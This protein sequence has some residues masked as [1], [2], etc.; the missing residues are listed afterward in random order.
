M[1]RHLLPQLAADAPLLA[2][3]LRGELGR[4]QPLDC[5]FPSTTPTSLV[6][7]GTGAQPG[8]HGVLGF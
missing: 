1:G 2:A 7:L 8:Q 6:S 3:V 5:T 4:L